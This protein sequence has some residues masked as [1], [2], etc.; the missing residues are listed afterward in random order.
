M[1]GLDIERFIHER[2]AAG[3][4][5]LSAEAHGEVNRVLFTRVLEHTRG[6]LRDAAKVLGIS[7]Q[8]LRVRLRSQGLQV[9]HTVED[10][11][12]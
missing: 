12:D 7:R 2:L 4:S 9:T 10:D 8:T 3:T 6:N 5:E 1:A 11:E